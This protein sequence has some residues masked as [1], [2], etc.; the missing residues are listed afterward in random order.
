MTKLYGH[1]GQSCSQLIFFISGLNKY[2]EG[3]SWPVI[4]MKRQLDVK[5]LKSLKSATFGNDYLWNVR[6]V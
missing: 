4:E 1:K 3:L 2:S 6:K 5:T